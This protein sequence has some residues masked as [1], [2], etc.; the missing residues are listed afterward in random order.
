MHIGEKISEIIAIRHSSKRKLGD[1]IGVTG[2]SATYLTF[3]K[4]ID[5]DTLARI[6]NAL[7]YNFFKHYPVA[8]LDAVA[9]PENI[10]LA[11]IKIKVEEMTKDLETYK[12]DLIIQQKENVYLKKINDLLEKRK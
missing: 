6:G 12:H 4:T 10:E 3:R 1:A 8:E 7:K 5:V 11:Q 2:S 9:L